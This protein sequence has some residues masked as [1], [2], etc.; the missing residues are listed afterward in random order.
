MSSGNLTFNG[1]FEAGMRAVA[2]LAAA[3]PRELDIQR[4]TAFDY[5]L[6]HT[7]MLGGPEDLHPE[8][9]ISTPATQVRRSIVQ[10]G[11]HL[12]M[13]RDLVARSARANGIVYQ[14][15]EL[16]ETFLDALQSP[17]S[18]KLKNRA[19]WLVKHLGSYEEDDFDRLMRR[20]FDQWV[21]EFQHIEQAIGGAA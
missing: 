9:P 11:L 5:L 21:M 10:D 17:Y 13:T 19:E 2:I 18:T 4:L 1:P 3:F 16:A 7:E 20:F 12:M 8:T 14:A 6:V 15:G